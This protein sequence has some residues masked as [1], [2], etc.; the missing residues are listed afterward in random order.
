MC[1]MN[2]IMYARDFFRISAVGSDQGESHKDN[3]DESL[4]LLA[5]DIHK[6]GFF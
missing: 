2:V 6:S 1:C 4:G 5:R 3:C